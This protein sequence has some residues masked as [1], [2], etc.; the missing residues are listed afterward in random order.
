MSDFGGLTPEE[1]AQLRNQE[2]KSM[3]GEQASPDTH[4]PEE[5]EV[6]GKQFDVKSD[7]AM[8]S[9]QANQTGGQMSQI[10][11]SLT[12][13]GA[14]SGNPYVA[15]AGL[16]LQTVGAVDSAKRQQE[17][18][19]IDAYNRKIMAQRSAVRNFFE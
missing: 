16:A 3:V 7:Q 2:L 17:Q 4:L 9:P 14:M 15:G 6:A 12:S 18:A 8:P 10:G 5:V 1:I 13:A 11:G 19:K